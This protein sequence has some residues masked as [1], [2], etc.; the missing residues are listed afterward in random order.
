MSLISV[1]VTTPAAVEWIKFNKD[2]VGYYRVNYPTEMWQSLTN[3]LIENR[4]VF[5]VADRAHLISDVFALADAGQ[6]EYSIAL[7]LSKYLEK[8]LDFVAWSVGA[9]RLSAIKNLLYFTSLYRD[10]VD[11][12]RQLLK[13]VYQSVT[14][15]VGE[16]HLQK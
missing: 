11:Y 8:E 1:S 3:A 6:V 15:T 16:D 4:G 13:N 2:Q 7:E 14:W 9:S 5:S 10:F 12:A